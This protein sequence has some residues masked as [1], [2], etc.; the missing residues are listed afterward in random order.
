M[1]AQ[2]KM[3]DS[4]IKAKQAEGD[5]SLKMAQLQNQNIAEENK[6]QALKIDAVN[7]AADRKAK[8]QLEG[9]R[10]QQSQLVH[11]DKLT[12]AERMKDADMMHAQTTKAAELDA[13]NQAKGLDL[14]HQR[15]Q[16][17]MQAAHEASQAAADRLHDVALAH[18]Q[19]KL[20]EKFPGESSGES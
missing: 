6:K 10:L 7:H 5:M 19:A 4:S 16:F 14:E 15:R 3:L 1:A 9:M 13:S 17:E 18:R 8:L 2:A 12:Q 11:R 20:A